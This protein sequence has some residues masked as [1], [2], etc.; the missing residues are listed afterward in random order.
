MP[1]AGL[2]V[3]GKM[4]GWS[5]PLTKATRHTALCWALGSG[6]DYL[7]LYDSGCNCSSGT[8]DGEVLHECGVI[9]VVMIIHRD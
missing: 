3:N 9:P 5:L 6:F 8:I 2:M 1:E 4:N 7:G